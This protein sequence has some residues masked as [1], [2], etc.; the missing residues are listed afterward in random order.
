[1]FDGYLELGGNEIVN[2]RR[3]AEYVR[4]NAPSISLKDCSDCEGVAE[5]QG[6]VYES[7]KDDQA[8]WFDP[9]VPATADFYGVYSL[10]AE[11]VTDSTWTAGVTEALGPGGTVNAGRHTTRTMRWHVMLVAGTKLALEAGYTWLR[12]ALLPGDCAGGCG[13]TDMCYYLA[14][15]EICRMWDP[16]GVQAGSGFPYTVDVETVARYRLPVAGDTLVLGSFGGVEQSVNSPEAQVVRWG[17]TAADDDRVEVE[18]YG[19]VIMQTTNV[20]PDPSMTHGNPAWSQDAVMIRPTGGVDGGPWLHAGVWPD[21]QN[22]IADPSFENYSPEELGWAPNLDYAP[23]AVLPTRELDETAPDGEYTITVPITAD[24]VVTPWGQVRNA[25]SLPLAGPLRS[26]MTGFNILWDAIGEGAMLWAVLDGEG[27]VV[28]S[29][30]SPMDLET[31]TEWWGYQTGA[32]INEIAA[33]DLA[34][35]TMQ[36]IWISVDEPT[37]PLRLDKLALTHGDRYIWFDGTTADELEPDYPW[38][39]SFGWTNGT[40]LGPS[41]GWNT[42]S[43]PDGVDFPFFRPIIAGDHTVSFWAKSDDPT[44]SISVTVYSEDFEIEYATADFEITDEWTRYSFPASLPIANLT[45]GAYSYGPEGEGASMWGLD[46]VSVA[47]GTLLLPYVDIDTPWQEAAAGFIVGGWPTDE[48]TVTQIGDDPQTATAQLQWNGSMTFGMRF[49][50]P[51]DWIWQPGDGGLCD[52]NP[53]VEAIGGRREANGSYGLIFPVSPETQAIPYSRTMHD[54]STTVGARTIQDVN[55]QNGFMREVEFFLTAGVPFAY[56]DETVVVDSD[57]A[58]LPTH[59]W[60]EDQCPVV[61][62]API[63]DPDCPTPPSPPRPP[64]IV[65]SCVLTETTWRRSWVKIP[66]AAVSMWS[67]TAPKIEITSG[68][69]AIREVR[70]RVFRNPFDRE[71]DAWGRENLMLNPR[72]V[73]GGTAWV[74]VP[75]T[76]GVAPIAYVNRTFIGE[77]GIPADIDTTARMTWTTAPT[78]GVPSLGARSAVGSVTPGRTYSLSIFGGWADVTASVSTTLR[79]RVNWRTAGGALVSSVATPDGVVPWAQ[80]GWPGGA[81]MREF[82]IEAV[83]PATASYAEMIVEYVNGNT[84]RPAINDTLY[85]TGAFMQKKPENAEIQTIPIDGIEQP[86]KAMD[87]GTILDT[88]MADNVVM[89]P[90]GSSPFL[91][92]SYG[93]TTGDAD[94]L[95]TIDGLEEGKAYAMRLDGF[96]GHSSQV[97]TFG[98]LLTLPM[99]VNGEIDVFNDDLFGSVFIAGGP[100]GSFA[101]SLE[102]AVET[103][104][105]VYGL[106]LWEVHYSEDYFDGSTPPGGGNYYQWTAGENTSSSYGTGGINVDPCDW[107]SEFILSYIP[108]HTTLSVDAVYERAFASVAGGPEQPADT[109]LFGSDGGPMS[110]PALTCNI[111]YLLAIDVPVDY[112]D[113]VNVKVTLSL[114]EV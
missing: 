84:V 94:L 55:L 32:A 47:F 69:N 2:S 45:L 22:V 38:N 81:N 42:P 46:R 72:A 27:E 54:V 49:G 113:D 95:F 71:I 66:A 106:S 85:A 34:G 14:C 97:L 33:G 9:T 11:G 98:N 103:S 29:T 62:L 101:V 31:S 77:G 78:A 15:P 43:T 60:G 1:M 99:T 4:K 76:T 112:V 12:S 102:S 20:M 56:G 3:A 21:I 18:S 111:P 91:E 40:P 7:P 82:A 100:V 30:S 48:Y 75:G 59:V 35:W 57:F 67:E 63:V 53:F 25:F 74:G 87:L 10:G 114:R 6:E 104:M 52:A 16:I 28:F 92:F 110:W 5:A 44:G 61:E 105:R 88:A 68:D 23:N 107:C 8:P 65:N 90:Q 58:N 26:G 41:D 96:G 89:V 39:M 79:G 24:G 17:A 19:P 93:P 13:G 83:A 70:A 37:M 51:S 50:N 86:F 109:L 80:P 36:C 73:A 64:E 108:A